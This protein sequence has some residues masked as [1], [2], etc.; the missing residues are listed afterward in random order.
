MFVG[1]LPHILLVVCRGFVACLLCVF[2]I[3]SASLQHIYR[4]LASILLLV[5]NIFTTCLLLISREFAA[6]LP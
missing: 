1:S 3:F 5:C 6:I 2:H 4:E